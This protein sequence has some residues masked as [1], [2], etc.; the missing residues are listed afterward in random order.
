M[1][2]A[3][4]L[5]A[6]GMGAVLLVIVAHVVVV[7][8]TGHRAVVVAAP[9]IVA[10]A[11]TMTASAT[12]A[13]MTLATA[14]V[15]FATAVTAAT[16]TAATTVTPAMSAVTAAAGTSLAGVDLERVA[17]RH[18]AGYTGAD[19][20]DRVRA[21]VRRRAETDT[22]FIGQ[23]AADGHFVVV[24]ALAT[25]VFDLDVRRV[26][27]WFGELDHHAVGSFMKCSAG[28]R[29]GAQHL[30]GGERGCGGPA[31]DGQSQKHGAQC[32]GEPHTSRVRR[33]HGASCGCP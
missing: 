1:F 17:V 16:M 33:G 21:V 4:V 12:V 9:I 7:A 18:G 10:S 3:T 27:E 2:P 20:G 13:T 32:Q 30:R 6:P 5:P 28:L 24:D 23:G 14:T 11:A 31:D 8:M 25:A 22:Q 19:V 15:T 29:I 26:L